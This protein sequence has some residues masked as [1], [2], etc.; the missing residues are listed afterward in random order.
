MRKLDFL[1]QRGSGEIEIGSGKI[2][3][4]SNVSNRKQ[5]MTQRDKFFDENEKSNQYVI[6]GDI[7]NPMGDYS[8]Y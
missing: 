8:D 4:P 3:I 1:H 2:I 6:F 5:Y 7:N